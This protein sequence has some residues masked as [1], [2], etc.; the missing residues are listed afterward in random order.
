[1]GR[2]TIQIPQ[3]DWRER[4][5]WTSLA[6]AL[7]SL[8]LLG[9]VGL[10]RWGER[11]PQG[12]VAGAEAMPRST[13]RMADLLIPPPAPPTPFTP[14]LLQLPAVAAPP[15]AATEPE[16]AAGAALHR[17]RSRPQFPVRGEQCGVAP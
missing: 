3:D 14:P 10:A 4:L 16:C 5:F 9:L 8:L 17:T 7:I 11:A 6:V 2:N 12:G 13:G 1:M 15:R